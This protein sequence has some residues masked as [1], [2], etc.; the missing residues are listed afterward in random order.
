MCGIAGILRFKSDKDYSRQLQS[1]LNSIAHRG[2]DGEGTYIDKTAGVYLG[3]KRLAILDLSEN[4]RQPMWVEERGVYITYNGEVY[5]FREIREEL[6][7]CGHVFHSDSDTEVI[8][9]SYIE[10][11]I[12]SLHRFRGMFAFALWDRPQGKLY[13]VRDRA[14][15][16]PL[17]Y[18]VNGE[19]IGFA[20]E[21]RA[22][23]VENQIKKDLCQSAL[24]HFLQ[25]GYISSPESIFTAVKTVPPGC[26]MVINPDGSAV[27]HKYWDIVDFY[28]QGIEEEK[29][30]KWQGISD[31]EVA[32]ELEDIMAKGFKYRL[33]SDVPV[34]LF[35]SGGIDSSVLAAVL[36][37]RE[38]VALNTFTIGYNDKDFNEAEFAKTTA[39][40][41]N[42]NHTE[43]YCEPEASLSLISR[44]T[45]IY[46][47]PFGDN[48][49]IPTYLVSELARKSVKVALSADGADE[50]FCGYVRFNFLDS[51]SK[52]LL[53]APRVARFLSESAL[54]LLTPG[55][56]NTLYNIAA[57]GTKKRAAIY[58]K[59]LKVKHL[60]SA[61]TR[62]EQYKAAS[63]YWRSAELPSL[64]GQHTVNDRLIDEVFNDLQEADLITQMMATEF[65]KYMVDDVL[66]KVDRASMAVSLEAREP[67][68][69]QALVEY[70]A[71]LPSHFKYRNGENKYILK[72]I[73]FKYLPEQNFQRPKQ[74]FSMPIGTWLRG[75]LKTQVEEY[76]DYNRIQSQGIFNPVEVEKAKNTFFNNGK[77]S[78]INIWY[79]MEFQMWYQRWMV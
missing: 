40:L 13:L 67:F 34:G 29:A 46:D 69:D 16:K 20:S 55:V 77:I 22:L 23:L 74:G 63:S 53:R 17:Y 25:Y 19:T 54:D 70:T 76:L 58:D 12:D 39:A 57:M 21:L 3:H 10:W 27:T 1:M 4:G 44:I 26:Y 35:L 15:V 42:T 66:A 65:K 37:K 8:L 28:R 47:E 18:Y 51:Y 60:L 2:P 11:G 7:R 61:N 33:V 50:L 31:D 14:G 32:E 73:L 9:K 30:G 64:L 68:L 56:T 5:N 71:K 6:I 36:S 78:P 45:D 24:S 49:L 48:S 59:L 72:K 62:C 41:L 43:L 38:G 75:A 52:S 79:L